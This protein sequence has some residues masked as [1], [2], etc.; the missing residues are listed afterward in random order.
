MLLHS[1]KPIGNRRESD[2]MV[3]AMGDLNAMVG[4]DIILMIATHRACNKT[5]RWVS[6]DQLR[7][8]SSSFKSCLLNVC[9]KNGADNGAKYRRFNLRERVSVVS[10]NGGAKSAFLVL[11]K[12]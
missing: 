4:S 7:I 3:I 10:A 5:A 12:I 11:S 2:V 6:T 1:G 8:Y 9:N